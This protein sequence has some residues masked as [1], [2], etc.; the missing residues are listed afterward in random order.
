MKHAIVAGATG[1]TGRYLMQHL[2][3]SPQWRVTGLSRRKPDLSGEFRHIP[4]NLLDAGDCRAKLA[5]LGDVTHVF[6]AAYADLADPGELAEVNLCMLRNLVE[7]VASASPSLEHV[8]LVEGTKWYGSH[9]G[10]FKTPA[11][12]SDP[13]P[14]A[15]PFFY[16][17]QQDWLESSQHGRQWSWSAI[18]PH[19]I[20]GFSVGSPM[21]LIVV[22]V[23]GH[24][25]GTRSTPVPPGRTRQLPHS[26]SSDRCGTAGACDR[27]DVH[28]RAMPEP[29]VQRHQW[30]PVPMGTSVAAN[31]GIFWARSRAA[32]SFLA[33]NVH[34]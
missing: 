24:L 1:V 23:R 8:H 13:R 21:N 20:S 29:G 25:Q 15:E 2:I 28:F 32:T 14:V 27:V 31:R 7:T 22:I 10:P 12:E 16:Y 30:R 17:A 33:A 19:T 9:L 6:H 11:K 26:L 18:R 34:V 5:S 4:V 3:D